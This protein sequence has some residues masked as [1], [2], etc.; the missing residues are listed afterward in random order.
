MPPI[1]FWA[2]T[3]MY[4]LH[5][6]AAVTWVGSL[7]AISILVLPAARRTLQPMEQ[8]ALIAAIQ[9]KVEGVAWF[10]LGLLAATG[11]FQMSSNPHYD[12]F[13][14]TSNQWSL[15]MLTKHTLTIV[16]VVFSAIQSWDVMPAIRRILLRREK[17]NRK[18][19]AV[20]QR[21]EMVLAWINLGLAILVFGATAVAR[22]S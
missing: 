9:G 18:E 20:L 22:A 17:A 16:M 6:L 14:A 10:S 13:L 3:L 1:P 19:L 5:M 15:A 7:A 21:R 8:L 2:L 4:W 11:L 12:G